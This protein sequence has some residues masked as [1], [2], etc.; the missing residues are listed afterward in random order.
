MGSMLLRYS[1]LL[2]ELS[3][4]CNLLVVAKFVSDKNIRV[5]YKLCNSTVGMYNNLLRL[6]RK[7]PFL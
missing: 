3:C 6:N 2:T 7:F 5:R 4:P 1:V